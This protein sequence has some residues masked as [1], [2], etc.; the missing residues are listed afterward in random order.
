MLKPLVLA[1]LLMSMLYVGSGCSTAKPAV[2]L[3]HIALFVTNLQT[4]SQF[5]KNIVGLD[6]IAEPFHDGRHA[7]FAI[8][9]HSQLHLIQGLERPVSHNKNTHLCFSVPSVVYFANNLQQKN[10]AYEDWAGKTSAITTRV[11]GVKQIYLKD[12][13]GFWLEINDHKF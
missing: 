2:G 10:V 11:D 12:P 6:T 7:W 5:Y 9:K 1:L 13:D 3:N 4:S 8:G